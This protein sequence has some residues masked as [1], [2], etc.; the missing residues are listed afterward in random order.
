MEKRLHALNGLER[1]GSLYKPFDLKLIIVP[2]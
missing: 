2:I 1:V